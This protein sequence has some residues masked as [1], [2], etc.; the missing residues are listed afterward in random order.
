MASKLDRLRAGEV[1]EIEPGRK[2][3]LNLQTKMFETS[4]G[5]RIYAG[6]DQDFFPSSKE[7][8]GLSQ[9]REKIE[10]GIQKIPGGEF[11]F[12][13][14]NQGVL[15]GA[16]DWGNKLYLKGDEYLE[17][18]RA[19]QQVSEGISER[20][21][22]TSAA[23][24]A[25]SFVP[26][27]ALTKGMS[28]KAAVPLLTAASAGTRLLDEP[29]EVA[30]EALI[31]GAAGHL[32]DKG[33]GAL[34]KMAQRRGQLR[35]L[36]AQQAQ[37]REANLLGQKASDAQNQLERQNFL[38]QKQFV[39]NQN[40]ARLHQH[41]LD[42]NAR[43]NQIIQDQNTYL[44][45]K[46][47]R[48]AEVFR[49]KTEA[50][51]ARAAS[52]A[53]AQTKDAAYKKA[54]AAAEQ[55]DK[56][57]REAHRLSLKKYHEDL[58]EVPKM[59]RQAQAEHGKNVAA[60]AEKIGNAFP[61]NARMNT[62]QFGV[63]S[64]ID[65]SMQKTGLIGSAQGS[66]ASRILKGIF[67]EGA[68]LTGKELATKYRALE[69]AIQRSSPDVQKVLVSFKD[70]L[71]SR[72][73]TIVEDTVSHAKMLPAIESQLEKD[74]PAVLKTIPF[75]RGE[76]QT[77]QLLIKSADQNLKQII[78]EMG[79]EN[80][81]KRLESGEL[82]QALKDRLLPLDDFLKASNLNPQALKKQGIYDLV[83]KE[84][85]G[86]HSFFM[87]QMDKRIKNTLAR[88]E[89][90]AIT[91]GYDH[92]KKIKG[93]LKNTYGMAEPVAVPEAPGPYVAPQMPTPPEAAAQVPHVQLPPLVSPPQTPAMPQKPTLLPPP[94]QPTPHT[95]APQPEPNLAP[96]QGLG[97][98]AADFLE[99]PLLNGNGGNMNSL[100]KLGALKYALGSAAA[101]LEAAGAAA[102]G[103]GKLLTSPTAAGEAARM[104]FRQ[105]GIEAIKS[106][107]MRYPTYHDGI[108][109]S[110]IERRSLTKEIEDDHEIP[111]EQKAILQSQVNRGKPIGQRI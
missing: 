66:Q 101:P 3:R 67:P 69:E 25:A 105:G 20:S 82:A 89:L 78:K 9:R 33:A 109:E 2:G 41:N 21:P 87:D 110:P 48:D 10:K 11:L 16:A 92:V 31:G 100:L 57:D 55:K 1:V 40:A 61:K 27:I 103:A 36:P 104:S 23:A 72:L 43:Q 81:V 63:Q 53:D 107:A 77:Q 39:E 18:K 58:K 90:K 26:D 46:A 19:M 22:W 29:G 71:G 6:D 64:F 38:N 17:N 93:S 86:K 99:R 74:I 70:H 14:G 76:A 37:V 94:S 28:A 73:P 8:L 50:E 54:K 35:E 34:N 4:D 84:M 85:E 13:L 49:L 32:I 30:K 62:G 59:Q 108:L 97:K 79:P 47:A 75:G 5:R 12:Q 51:K 7:A 106:W 95:F 65:E 68:S 98:S 111:I 102:Y 96:T 42:L 56:V 45:K 15:G 80:F 44:G 24:K 60:N 83:A 91:A 52:A 88:N